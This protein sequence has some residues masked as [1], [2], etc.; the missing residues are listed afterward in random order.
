MTNAAASPDLFELALHGDSEELERTWKESASSPGPVADYIPTLEV[1]V[2][3]GRKGFAAAAGTLLAKG[4]HDAGRSVEAVDVL[5][6]MS[7]WK[8][9][10][11]EGAESICATAVDA[12]FGKEP[13]LDYLLGK[14]N[15]ARGDAMPWPKWREVAACLGFTPGR[16]VE[17]RSGWGAGS[18]GDLD[19]ESDEVQI[20]FASGRQHT[21]P[22]QT[23]M[24]TMN[25]L[26]PEDLR[27]MRLQ[28]DKEALFEF[29]KAQPT[30]VLRRAMRIYRGK[31]TS[32]QIKE[33]LHESIVPAKSWT[34]W[35]KKAKAAA[36]EDPLIAV[37]GSASRPTLTL[38]KKALTLTDE[39]R[40]QLK[41]EKVAS[42]IVAG[43][44]AFFDRATRDSDREALAEHARERLGVFAMNSEGVESA[45]AI[46]F[47]EEIGQLSVEE[48][49][50][51]IRPLFGIPS[52]GDFDPLSVQ[53]EVLAEIDESAIRSRLAS[54]LPSVL[55]PHWVDAALAKLPILSEYG[56]GCEEALEI[57]VDH[58]REAKVPDRLVTLYN[59]VAPFP[60]KHPFLIYLLTKAQG[61]GALDEASEEIDPNVLCRVILH[62]LRVVCELHTGRRHTRLQ[63]RIQTLL[64][65]RKGVLSDLLERIDRNTMAS[66]IKSARAGGEDF[67]AKVQ[68]LIEASARERFPEFFQ[69][70]ELQFWEDEYDIFVTRKGFEHR[71]GEF[72]HLRDDLIPANSKAIG[73]AASLGD[74]SENAEWEAAIEE[75]RNLTAKASE[76]E[77]ELSRARLIEE[78]EIPDD[79]VA[80][81]TAVG[82][83]D[84]E[85]N[86]S[87]TIRILGPWDAHLGDDVVSYRAPLAKGLL[88]SEVGGEVEIQLP[89]G[90]I[91]LR[92]DSIKK[93]F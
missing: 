27:A 22:W 21:V 83:H 14:C 3:T 41:F 84:L 10:E 47:L 77:D 74:L 76:W 38:R 20:A 59:R 71:E 34:S 63:S 39:A 68:E 80:P 82:V 33:Q 2:E 16:A 24:D 36:V 65:G 79:I 12:A 32:T 44:R 61:D 78:V 43:L 26:A 69:E 19:V 28:D 56:E 54:Q 92:V 67:P 51:M 4:L 58:L 7:L 88:G 6:R 55:G 90:A 42:K 57:L 60:T 46:M 29:A 53:L 11:A 70:V 35:W 17:H 85:K 18:I 86:E 66:A 8:I 40:A 9:E 81:G 25:Q 89:G 48:A 1:L 13:W 49:A 45:H 72:H 50:P 30:V 52:E 23:A 91:R 93:L 37:E 5:I 75:Q 87:K 64:S 15:V 73:E 62:A 31:A